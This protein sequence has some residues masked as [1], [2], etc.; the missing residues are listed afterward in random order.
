MVIIHDIG[1]VVC[2]Q[3]SVLHI[4][5]KVTFKGIEILLSPADIENDFSP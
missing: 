3:G 5:E 2:R 1:H 4:P